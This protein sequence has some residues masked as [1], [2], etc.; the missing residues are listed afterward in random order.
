MGKNP[1]GGEVYKLSAVFAHV[2]GSLPVSMCFLLQNIL[3][4]ISGTAFVLM[5][6]SVRGFCQFHTPFLL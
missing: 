3:S 2:V 4:R 5:F 1:W 6:H